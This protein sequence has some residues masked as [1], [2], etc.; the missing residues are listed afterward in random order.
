MQLL[1]FS[2]DGLNY[3]I[4]INNVE[5]IES[6]VDVVSIPAA[7]PHVRGIIRIH[8]IIIPVFNLA[9]RF[10]VEGD[11]NVENLVVA[12]VGGMRIGLEV[13][14]VKEIVEIEDSNVLPLP[15]IVSGD[16]GCFSDVATR[17]GELIAMLNVG[18][19]VN[20]NERESIQK[21][22]DENTD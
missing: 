6:R 7:P 16:E 10:G 12:S 15:H 5:S 1:T 9:S 13:E 4:P 2:L 21:M 18:S 8:G 11:V 14:H 20:V 3:G 19:L 22:L 17:Q